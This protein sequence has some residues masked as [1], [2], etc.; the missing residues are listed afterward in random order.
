MPRATTP[1]AGRTPLEGDVALAATPAVSGAHARVRAL[2]RLLDAAVRVP[3][4][5]VRVGLDAL[6]GLIPGVG[7]VAGVAFYGYIILAAARLGVPVPVV[8]RMLL[9]VAT[10]TVVGAVPL[11]GDIFDVG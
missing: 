7:D 4:T 8:L 10:D 11:V 1:A 9:N 6:I 5:N 3:G 2:A